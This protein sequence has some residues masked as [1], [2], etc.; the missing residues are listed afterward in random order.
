MSVASF[1]NLS[2]VSSADNA[3]GSLSW[4]RLARDCASQS[5]IASYKATRFSGI[6]PSCQC[7]TA[8][9][10]SIT[11]FRPIRRISGFARMAVVKL[12]KCLAR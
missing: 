7:T 9:A 3:F 12:S 6:R 5:K 2:I 8:N 10:V 11:G 4:R 1:P